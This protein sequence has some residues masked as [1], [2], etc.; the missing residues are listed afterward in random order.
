VTPTR[1]VPP[2]PVVG[3]RLMDQCIASRIG[4]GLNYEEKKSE[5]IDLLI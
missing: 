3:S 4:K 2:P 1:V 5:S